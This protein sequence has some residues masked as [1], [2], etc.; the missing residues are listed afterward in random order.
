MGTGHTIFVTT[1]A[2]ST[3][4]INVSPSLRRYRAAEWCYPTQ[5]T[6]IIFRGVLCAFGT[7]GLIVRR[8]GCSGNLFPQRSQ[9][10]FFLFL[11]V[12]S[13]RTRQI[14]RN[15][16]SQRETESRLARKQR[17]REEYRRSGSWRVVAF[18]DERLVGIRLSDCRINK[19]VVR[20]IAS[21]VK[22][23]HAYCVKQILGV[24]KTY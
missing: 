19:F 21:I 4:S 13:K 24:L 7:Q 11:L 12:R 23:S 15:Q 22:E 14:Y 6:S 1:G 9:Q 18:G 3:A 8:G 10:R 5:G 2:H 20:R 17:R 16:T